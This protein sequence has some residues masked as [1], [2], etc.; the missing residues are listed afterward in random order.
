M[1][2]GNTIAVTS[3][4]QNIIAYTPDFTTTELLPLLLS[5]PTVNSQSTLS[6]VSV[7]NPTATWQN[8]TIGGTLK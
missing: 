8:L 2:S 3:G 7:T 4:N 1:Q 6:N 5:A